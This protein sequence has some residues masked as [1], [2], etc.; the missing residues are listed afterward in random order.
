MFSLYRGLSRASDSEADNKP[1]CH[2]ATQLH[3]NVLNLKKRQ[4]DNY[5]KYLFLFVRYQEKITY[6]GNQSAK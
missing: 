2:C 1:I 6:N 3:V 5:K 4:L